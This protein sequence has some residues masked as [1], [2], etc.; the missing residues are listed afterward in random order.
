[1]NNRVLTEIEPETKRLDKVKSWLPRIA[2]AVVFIYIGQTKFSNDPH[3]Q[4][5]PIFDKIGWGQ[6]FR[7]FTGVMQVTGGVLVLI[8]KTLTIGAAMLACTMVGA[9]IVDVFVL[10][11]PFF[12]IPLFFLAAIVVTWLTSWL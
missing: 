4:W 11:M 6:W 9:T 1:M 5:I 12:F 8:P 3:S 10:H 2:L 7:Y